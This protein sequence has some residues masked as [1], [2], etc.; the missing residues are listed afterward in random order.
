MKRTASKSDASSNRQNH[1]YLELRSQAADLA[2]IEGDGWDRRGVLLVAWGDLSAVSKC[3]LVLVVEV[4]VLTVCG[5]ERTLGDEVDFADF[6]HVIVLGALILERSS[7][8]LT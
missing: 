4:G 7:S 2:K 3:D 1:Y 6:D 5:L 8:N